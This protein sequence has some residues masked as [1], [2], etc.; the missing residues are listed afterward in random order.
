MALSEAT[1]KAPDPSPTSTEDGV[2][3]KNPPKKSQFKPGQSGNPKGRPKGSVS[4][5]KLL[6]KWMNT[7]ISVVIDGKKIN[8]T[9]R[10]LIPL[11]LLR[12]AAKG[13]IPHIKHFEALVE[14]YGLNSAEKTTQEI[15]I[16][17]VKPPEYPPDEPL[18]VRPFS[19]E[20]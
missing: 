15:R 20:E 8:Q 17:F 4:M 10:E 19:T 18:P 12:H 3:Y 11:N 16:V 5:G 1:D 2:G 6:E 9:Y 7:K 13:S 14:K